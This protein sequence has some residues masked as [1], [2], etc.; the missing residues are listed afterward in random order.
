MEI[1]AK[2]LDALPQEPVRVRNVVV[3]VQWTL[4]SS[5][6]CGLSSTIIKQGPHGVITPREVGDLTHKSA[7]ELAHWALS[8]NPIEVSI[9]IAAI[10]SL[11]D[12]SQLSVKYFNVAEVI[13]KNCKDRNLAIVG[14][15]PFSESMKGISRNFWS[16]NEP[17]IDSLTP[18][19]SAGEH[20]SQA[21]VVV[22]TS[23][24]FLNH[25]TEMFLAFCKP[26]A[27]VM[28]IGPTTPISP[29]LFQYKISYISGFNVIDEVTT[30]A[31]VQQGASFTQLSGA[32][33]ISIVKD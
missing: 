24:T 29:I 17:S 25:S 22:I 28:V 10:N 11:I 4:V 16:V 3:G 7:Q 5:S 20:I 27:L 30:T 33:L 21:D 12:I 32:R 13:S 1:I 9:G 23:T 14:D 2:L 31:A 26:E 18:N 19:S 8:D 6:Y 15:F